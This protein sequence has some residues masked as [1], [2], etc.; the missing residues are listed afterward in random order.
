MVLMFNRPTFHNEL[1]LADK[2]SHLIELPSSIIPCCL[3]CTFSCFKAQS[4]SD[5]H[6]PHSSECDS[7][8]SMTTSTCRQRMYE[9]SVSSGNPG[10]PKARVQVTGKALL[11]DW[12]LARPFS[13]QGPTQTM[14]G[15]I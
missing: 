6:R 10:C 12:L 13:K 1:A 7:R 5:E 15:P 14:T 8:R 11:P 3:I 9:V 2:T 4:S